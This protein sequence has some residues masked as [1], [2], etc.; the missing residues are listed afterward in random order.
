MVAGWRADGRAGGL[1]KCRAPPA[2]G[3]DVAIWEFASGLHA[4]MHI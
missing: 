3:S 1:M 4:C 2:T